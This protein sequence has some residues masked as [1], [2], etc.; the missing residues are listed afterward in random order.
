V[1]EHSY[2]VAMLVN[3][4]INWLDAKLPAY[5]VPNGTKLSM[6]LYALHHDVAEGVTGDITGP[7]KKK[8]IDAAAY[9]TYLEKKEREL[10]GWS[11]TADAEDAFTTHERFILKMCDFLEAV[12]FVVDEQK[13]G[14]A[15]WDLSVSLENTL[16][17]MI[18]KIRDEYD[19]AFGKAMSDFAHAVISVNKMSSRVNHYEA[20][21]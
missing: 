13:M 11:P 3:D 19:E 6:L 16:F 14:N 8:I 17:G 9:S 21:Q 1:A 20:A 2:F 5:S 7:I 12:L 15:L 18:D 10:L 4:A